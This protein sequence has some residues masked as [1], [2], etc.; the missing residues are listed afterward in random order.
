MKQLITKIK[1][2]PSKI[3]GA[4]GL[5]TRAK[6]VAAVTEA[7]KSGSALVRKHHLPPQTGNV[8][9]NARSI[10]GLE[11][12]KPLAGAGGAVATFAIDKATKAVDNGIAKAV[13]KKMNRNGWEQAAQNVN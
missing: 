1:N 2:A 11:Y 6:K 3:G 5:N 4:L 13:D 9:E 10:H 7:K 8:I 12:K